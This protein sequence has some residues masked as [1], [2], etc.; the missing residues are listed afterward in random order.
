MRLASK[1]N[2]GSQLA[3]VN[4]SVM[5]LIDGT[6]PRLAAAPASCTIAA[7]RSETVFSRTS[8]SRLSG[9]K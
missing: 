1:G 2:G 8:P 9:S 5:P 7:N 3:I 6:S 4:S